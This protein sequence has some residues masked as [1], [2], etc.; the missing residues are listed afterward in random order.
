MPNVLTVN[1]NNIGNKKACLYIL[2]VRT[3]TSVQDMRFEV[4]RLRFYSDPSGIV[5]LLGVFSSLVKGTPSYLPSYRKSEGGNTSLNAPSLYSN[6]Y[7]FSSPSMVYYIQ[8]VAGKMQLGEIE[9]FF[10]ATA[11]KYGEGTWQH[12]QSSARS[13]VFL[14]E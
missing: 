3:L 11:F 4:K 9:M 8:Y 13:Y 1:L 2:C 12:P 14:M 5:S 6:T 7:E 10:L